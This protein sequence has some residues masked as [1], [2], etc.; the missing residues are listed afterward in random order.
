ML[1]KLKGLAFPF[2][3]CLALSS[4]QQPQDGR[5]TGFFIN[6]QTEQD[7][8][9]EYRDVGSTEFVTSG[10]TIEA[11][12]TQPFLALFGD[13]LDVPFAKVNVY[14]ATTD[15]TLLRSVTDPSEYRK[16]P[17]GKTCSWYIDL[18]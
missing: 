4:C 1:V 15:K 3:T 14:A 10:E 13:C 11:G 17:L 9:V 5:A 7:I 8:T 12:T 18:R 6:N 16:E 2:I